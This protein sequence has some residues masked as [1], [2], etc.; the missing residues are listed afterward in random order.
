MR[1]EIYKLLGGCERN[2][3]RPQIEM[4][5]KTN[6]GK[7]ELVKQ[8]VFHGSTCEHSGFAQDEW[9]AN[10]WMR[11]SSYQCIMGQG[12]QINNIGVQDKTA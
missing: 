3:K 6:Y 12:E 11:E 2:G 1:V 10:H 7:E 8:R 9:G 4:I 5:K